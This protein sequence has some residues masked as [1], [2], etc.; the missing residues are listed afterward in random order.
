[1]KPCGT[2]CAATICGCATAPTWWCHTSMPASK[3]GSKSA[4]R[5]SCA[6]GPP[7]KPSTASRSWTAPHHLA[8]L[9]RWRRQLRAWW[10]RQNGGLPPATGYTALAAALAST[11]QGLGRRKPAPA[12]HLRPPLGMGAAHPRRSRGKHPTNT[13]ASG[14][15]S[16][17][18]AAGK[19][20][21]RGFSHWALGK[22]AFPNAQP[23]PA[24]RRGPPPPFS[25]A[26]KTLLGRRGMRL[27]QHIEPVFFVA[28]PTQVSQRP[29]RSAF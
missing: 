25:A 13:V 27:F 12:F 5:G 24:I 22:V 17:T 4:C 15:Y 19:G 29:V 9:W 8:D 21:R 16:A 28:L 3:A 7:C 20:V 18:A 14:G 1:M 11:R 2:C 10:G 26:L 6:S 23:R